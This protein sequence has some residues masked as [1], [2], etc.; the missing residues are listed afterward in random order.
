VDGPRLRLLHRPECGLC[1]EMARD[2]R[3]LRVAFEPLDIEQDEALEQAYGEHIPVLLLD[4]REVA[5]APQSERSLRT[6]LSR[7]GLLRALP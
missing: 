6:L 7:A 3:R 2:L 5:R 1:E 4:G